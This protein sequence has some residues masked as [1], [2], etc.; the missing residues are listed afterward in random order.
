M[1]TVAGVAKAP[2]L[3]LCGR[4][5]FASVISAEGN[6]VDVAELAS[7]PM[8][9]VHAVFRRAHAL[10]VL[11]L[12]PVSDFQVRKPLVRLVWPSLEDLINILAVAYC[13]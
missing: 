2:A 7:A 3:A 9:L 5:E 4:I 13:V 8:S 12:K 1:K 6:V 11:K 10:I